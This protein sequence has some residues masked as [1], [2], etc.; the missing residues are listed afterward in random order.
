[1]TITALTGNPGEGKTLHAVRDYIIPALKEKR[2]VVTN[3]PLIPSK[4]SSICGYDVEPFIYIKEEHDDG[5]PAFSKI[6]DFTE[7]ETWAQESGTGL[8]P[9]YV[10]D[11]CHEAFHAVVGLKGS[12][13]PI[14]L[15]MA[16]HRHK[17]ADVVLMTQDRA[18]L[19]PAIKRR[20]HVIYD[21]ERLGMLGMSDRY[22]RRQYR[23]RG[24]EPLDTVFGKI[25]KSVFGTY[26]TRRKGTAER[27]P[28]FRNILN[29]WQIW[30][31]VIGIA[32]SS[33]FAFRNGMPGLPGEHVAENAKSRVNQLQDLGPDFPPPAAAA[34]THATAAATVQALQDFRHAEE[35]KMFQAAVPLRGGVLVPS[36]D[37]TGAIYREAQPQPRHLYDGVS[38]RI[39]GHMFMSGQHTYWLEV[40]GEKSSTTQKADDL[41]PFG[42]DIVAISACRAFLRGQHGVYQLTCDGFNVIGDAEDQMA[43]ASLGSTSVEYTPTQEPVP[44]TEG[45]QAP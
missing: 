21:Y 15:W 27:R 40:R 20:V 43:R 11:E 13:H 31:I 22:V 32:I 23:K 17:G 33:Y 42:F 38:V 18:E 14:S 10:I 25:D 28:K 4:L 8:N 3:V 30:V 24:S 9:L 16:K 44:A 45:R 36:A 2:L 26:H 39:S 19:Q 6:E 29:R 12:E 35:F 37:G 1:M 7:Y 34:A 41:K 5:E